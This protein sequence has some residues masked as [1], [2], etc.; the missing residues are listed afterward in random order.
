MGNAK[1]MKI[2][3]V[4]KSALL[5]AE[6]KA[7]AKKR[8]ART[9]HAVL[10][11]EECNTLVS[12]GGELHSRHVVATGLIRA[13]LDAGLAPVLPVARL[14]GAAARDARIAELEAKLAALESGQ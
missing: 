14:K 11:V 13:A 3:G 5:T 8:A 4:V 12:L 1:K 6:Q 10:S 2:T 7:V 9:A